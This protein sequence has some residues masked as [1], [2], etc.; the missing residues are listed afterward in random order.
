MER[1]RQ[2]QRVSSGPQRVHHDVETRHHLV[3]SVMVSVVLVGEDHRALPRL[4]LVPVVHSS[5]H[6]EA[7]VRMVEVVV[8]VV[9][10]R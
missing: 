6:Q 1:Q 7:V 5:V 9:A 8:P 3:V 2:P 4:L 10:A